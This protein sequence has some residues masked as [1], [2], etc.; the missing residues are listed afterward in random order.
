MEMVT[1][2]SQLFVSLGM[3]P[4]EH[5]YKVMGLAAYT[6]EKYYKEVYDD[7]FK[8]LFT[9]DGL[10]WKAKFPM[11]RAYIYLRKKWFGKRFDN[12]A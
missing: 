7:M 11:N 12:I 9:I 1:D 5:E 10:E 2:T 8:D 3:K 4:I 6:S